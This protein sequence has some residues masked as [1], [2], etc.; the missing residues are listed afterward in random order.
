MQPAVLSDD[1]DELVTPVVR[2]GEDGRVSGCNAA[3]ARWLGVS[4]K[5]LL[6]QP[7]ASLEVDGDNLRQALQSA[8]DEDSAPRRLRRIALA[9]RDGEPS[10]A[11]AWLGRDARGILLEIHPVDEFPGED[12]ATALPLALSAAL[13]GL[14]HELRNPLAGLKGAAQLLERRVSD[15][16]SRELLELVRSEVDRLALLVDRLLSPVPPQPHQPVNIH[17]VLEQVLRLAET[18][19]GW[20]VRLVRDY[21][22]SLPELRGDPDR[23]TQAIWN[24]VRNA[25]QAGAA[26]VTLRTRAEFSVRI[27]DQVHPLVLRLEIID[28]GRGVPESLAEQIFV[29][30]VSGRA[31]GSGLGLALAQQVAREHRGSLG[32][33][34]RPRHTVFTLLL[35]LGD[36]DA[37]AG[38]S[39]DTGLAKDMND[40]D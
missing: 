18:D 15:P 24:L 1:Y 12:P 20:V 19:A 14:A 32:Y 4:R 22:P 38:R 33:R 3:F 23:L 9:F 8:G 17:G 29:P 26:Q 21:D 31:D 25:I 27:G 36:D 40:G 13:K 39:D 2:I 35:P 5:R 10:F 37:G 7:I 34:S 30:L 16:E 11:D 6:A 28:D